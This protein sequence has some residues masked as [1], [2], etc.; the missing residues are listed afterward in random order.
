MS[1]EL[2]DLID[3]L[4]SK[5]P[6]RNDVPSDSQYRQAVID[7]VDDFSLRASRE[8]ITTLQI[9]SGTATYDLPADFVKIIKLEGLACGDGVLNTSAGL[10]PLSSPMLTERITIS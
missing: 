10:I 1:T 5:V 6:A 8:K 2:S 7:A 9:V 3:K 4:Q